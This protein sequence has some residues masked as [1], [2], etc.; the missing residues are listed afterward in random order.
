MLYAVSEGLDNGS[1]TIT[2]ENE[3][4]NKAAQI[5]DLQNKAAAINQLNDNANP[6]LARQ[7]AQKLG[8]AGI[9]GYNKDKVD[10]NYET[11]STGFFGNSLAHQASGATGNST[12][13][14]QKEFFGYMY[15]ALCANG[16]SLNE[17][18]TD[19]QFLSDQMQRQNIIL[20]EYSAA[21][22]SGSALSIDDSNSGLG[23]VDST[24]RL[25][26]AEAAY[27]AESAQIDYKTSIIETQM[28]TLNTELTAIQSEKESIQSILSKKIEKFNLFG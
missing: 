6:L 26:A 13:A 17:S 4:P 8:T 23:L 7:N 19:D 16:W 9:N 21:S 25:E 14:A 20:Y 5:T 22:S 11:A 10:G 1:L 2:D 12:L 3:K 15:D 18:V 24:A 27:E 28:D